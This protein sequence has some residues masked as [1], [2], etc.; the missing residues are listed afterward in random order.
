M[1]ICCKPNGPLVIRKISEFLCVLTN[2]NIFRSRK[3]Y[4]PFI[5]RLDSVLLPSAA[6]LFGR[7]LKNARN[8]VRLKVTKRPHL[9]CLISR[10]SRHRTALQKFSQRNSRLC[11]TNIQT[12]ENLS[13]DWTSFFPQR[14]HAMSV[15]Q[16]KCF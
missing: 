6:S 2:A 1:S 14:Q 16:G 11:V 7:T 12:N 15:D 13:R 8:C 9:L 10:K 4:G 3:T 5:C